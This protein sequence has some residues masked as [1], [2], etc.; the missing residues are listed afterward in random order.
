MDH[1]AKV[2]NR[3]KILASKMEKLAGAPLQ[4]PYY[5]VYLKPGWVLKAMPSQNEFIGHPDFWED[6]AVNLV[7]PFYKIKDPRTIEQLKHLSYC[8]PRGRVTETQLRNGPK[9]WA[10][11]CG[12]DFRMS[13][14]EQKQILAQFNLL[15]QFSA[16][17]VRFRPDDHEIILPEEHDAFMRLVTQIDI[18]NKKRIQVPDFSNDPMYRDDD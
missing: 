14:A 10:V 2:Y 16:G 5:W 1:P 7:A 12:N 9:S 3:R 4:G 18:K 6:I 11:D 15:P 17:L 8:M 13:S